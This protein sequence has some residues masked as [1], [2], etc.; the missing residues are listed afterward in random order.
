MA[1]FD[2]DGNAISR[3]EWDAR[4]NDP[5]YRI[6]RS[7]ESEEVK[8][9]VIWLGYI[10]DHI[11]VPMEHWNMFEFNVYNVIMRTSGRKAYAKDPIYSKEMSR[12]DIAILEWEQFLGQHTECEHQVDGD[13]GTLGELVIKGEV[14]RDIVADEHEDEMESEDNVSVDTFQAN[15]DAGSW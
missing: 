14:F 3:V 8:A 1:Y 10:V 7:Y 15:P 6:V 11:N 9:E 2:H 13:T 5:D 4:Q 12:K